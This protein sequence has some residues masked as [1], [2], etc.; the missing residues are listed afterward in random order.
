MGSE[1]A[2]CLRPAR[3]L[4]DG[5]AEPS[6]VTDRAHQAM[7]G[8]RQGVGCGANVR[9]GERN[10]RLQE[11]AAHRLRPVVDH[12]CARFR[13]VSSGLMGD[14]SA[15][16]RARTSN[17]ADSAVSAHPLSPGM[18]VCHVCTSRRNASSSRPF[19]F[20]ATHRSVETRLREAREDCSQLE[21]RFA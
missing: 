20:C 19:P 14:G 15:L 4:H 12:L 17:A 11:P 16:S 13:R 7:C 3:S 8:A 18:P 2:Q 1:A 21:P 9:G 10:T 6:W 5:A